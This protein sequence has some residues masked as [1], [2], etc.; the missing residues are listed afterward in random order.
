MI[1]IIVTITTSITIIII[2]IIVVSITTSIIIIII[3]INIR[4]HSCYYSL[5]NFYV[6]VNNIE[7]VS[8]Y[9]HFGHEITAYLLVISY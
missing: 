8:N 4:M 9:F 2:N 5:S 3:C 1:I 6:K 7:S